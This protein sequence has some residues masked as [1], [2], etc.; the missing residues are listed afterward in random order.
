MQQLPFDKRSGNIWFNNELCEWQD[1]RVHIISH[2]MHYAS[3]VFEGIRVYNANIFKLEE[4]NQRLFHSAKIMD[5]KIPYTLDEINSATVKLVKDQNIKELYSQN[6][7][8]S[9]I[10]LAVEIARTAVLEIIACTGP[11]SRNRDAI[12]DASCSPRLFRG[13]SESLRSALAQEDLA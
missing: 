4:H 1:A 10:N 3:L 11:S 9:A 7:V 8:P 2:G 5:M 12:T 13:R 6:S